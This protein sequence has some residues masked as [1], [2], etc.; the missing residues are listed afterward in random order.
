MTDPELIE[1]AA[2]EDEIR[3]RIDRLETLE[4]ETVAFPAGTGGAA[5]FCDIILAAPSTFV[6]LCGGLN[7]IPQTHKHLW[8]IIAAQTDAE[9][10]AQKMRMN[11]NAGAMPPP[12]TGGYNY[13]TRQELSGGVPVGATD[14]EKKT[15]SL[16]PDSDA[17][18]WICH[19]AG[20]ED[21]DP[22]GPPPPAYTKQS[23]CWVQ[24]VDYTNP[25]N[26]LIAYGGSW[27]GYA[28]YIGAIDK[29][30]GG[31]DRDPETVLDQG[32]GSLRDG[33]R[34]NTAGPPTNPFAVTSIGIAPNVGETFQI[35]SQFTLYGV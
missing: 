23:A 21:N 28:T 24:V 22:G 4:Y 14:T 13:Y 34:S 10:A 31:Q 8:L 2:R 27:W 17:S 3:K 11:I 6:H 1:F 18:W 15:A 5:L 26:D 35:G 7:T 20:F 16:P 25:S 32:E 19:P 33:A 9:D 29:P 12:G 30:G